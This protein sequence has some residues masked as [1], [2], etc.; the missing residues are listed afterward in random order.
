MPEITVEV[1]HYLGKEEA[2]EKLRPMIDKLASKIEGLG[3]SLTNFKSGWNEDVMTIS[4][5]VKKGFVSLNISGK[6]E[7]LD[8]KVLFTLDVAAVIL[9]FID[10]AG[11]RKALTE[12]VS[13]V[14]LK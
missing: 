5:Q 13:E 7:V 10:E 3:A 4:G 12:S 8:E 1:S 6:M 9:K 11:I 2:K 14:L